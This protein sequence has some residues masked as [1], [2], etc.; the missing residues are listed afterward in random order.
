M[1]RFTRNARST[2]MYLR[3]SVVDADVSSQI[4]RDRL[5][6]TLAAKLVGKI[7]SV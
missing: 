3:R 2:D 1:V 5:P 4:P 7:L 6:L